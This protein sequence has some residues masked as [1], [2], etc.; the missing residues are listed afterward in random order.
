MKNGTHH[1]V[2]Q[3]TMPPTPL[4]SSSPSQIRLSRMAGPSERC[5]SSFMTARGTSVWYH[6]AAARP[7]SM[8]RCASGPV[9]E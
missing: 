3:N 5:M 9:I 6:S 4:N 7:R 8:A 1:Q 2:P